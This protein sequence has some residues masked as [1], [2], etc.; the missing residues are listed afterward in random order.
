MPIPVTTAEC[1][2]C[3]KVGP[4]ADF[5]RDPTKANGLRGHCREC[6]RERHLLNNFGLRAEQYQQM[7][8][9]QGGAC[10]IC[11]KPSDKTLAVDHC[12][13]TGRVRGLLCENCNRGIGLLGDDAERL[14]AAAEY[15]E[16]N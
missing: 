4:S 9:S 14:R 13:S 16:E 3:N 11:R 15:L 12:H 1:N 8:R 7:F 6:Q 10:K 2:I 5:Q